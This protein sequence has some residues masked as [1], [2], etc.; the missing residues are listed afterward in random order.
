MDY[1]TPMEDRYTIY[2][3]S[4]C[5]YCKKVIELLKYEI[6]Q[7]DEICCDEYI[8]DT[9][10]SKNRSIPVRVAHPRCAAKDNFFR[11]IQSIAKVKHQ[12]FPVVFHKGIFIGGYTE[13]LS[14]VPSTSSR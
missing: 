4:G 12:T 10:S 14:Y 2:T 11:F 8:S 13:T 7:I 3:R 1:L 9:E 5:S 6:P